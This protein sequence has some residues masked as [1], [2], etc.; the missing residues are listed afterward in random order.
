M[1]KIYLL[2]TAVA[3]SIS[4]VFAGSGCVVDQNNTALFNPTP[5]DVPCAE[6]GVAYNQTLHFFVP[7]SQDIT[8]AGQTV[9]V[10]VDSVVLN[11]VT[12]LPTGLS[13]S[14]NPTGPLYMPDTHGCGL[15]YGTTTAAPGNYPI[16][17]DGRM[18]MH[19]SAFGFTIDTS[20]TINQVIQQHYGKTYSIDV[21][22]QGTSCTTGIKDFNNDLNASLSVYPN[23]NAGI[24]TVKLNAGGRVNGTV[25]VID[26][27]GR[28]VFTQPVDVMGAYETNVNIS[29]L[30][31]GLYTVQLKTDRGIS[32][33]N[34]SVE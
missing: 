14:A 13:W 28:V 5:D 3:V 22:A 34:I 32:S 31:K 24:F 19:G 30:A 6:V 20:F 11:D 2:A 1:K 15:T 21:V 16:V 25:Q 12:G 17:F 4:A 7:V 9:T 33:K 10:Y 8:I 29:Q 27:T 18:Y 23:P 26:V